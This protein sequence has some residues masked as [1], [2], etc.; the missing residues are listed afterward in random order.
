MK[1]E[2]DCSVGD[3]VRQV[4][5]VVFNCRRMRLV[6]RIM[7]KEVRLDNGELHKFLYNIEFLPRFRKICVGTCWQQ[8]RCCSSSFVAVIERE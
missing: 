6:E 5:S 8:H 7:G 4:F 3:L 1:R 2:N